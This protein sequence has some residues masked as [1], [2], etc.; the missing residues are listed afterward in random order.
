[1]KKIAIIALPLSLF[2]SVIVTGQNINHWET[3]VFNS[4]T[5]SFH[6]GNSDPGDGWRSL[7]FDD[8]LWPEGP[9]GFGYGDNDDNTI[10]SP[11]L[12]LSS[13]TGLFSYCLI[14]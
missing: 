9:G 7:A 14:A 11:C 8:S 6:V 4:D 10:I 3:A 5:W 1:M 13:F 2:C 12:T